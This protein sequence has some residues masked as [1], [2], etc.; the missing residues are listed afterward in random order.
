MANLKNHIQK[1]D[2]YK[3]TQNNHASTLQSVYNTPIKVS[4]DE[5]KLLRIQPTTLH[6][7]NLN[8]LPTW[9]FQMTKRQVHHN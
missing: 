6:Y 1:N 2:T 3:D 7:V 5:T 4:N 9:M 8:Q